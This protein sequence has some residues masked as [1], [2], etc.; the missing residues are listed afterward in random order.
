MFRGS[1]MIIPD[2]VEERG[3]GSGERLSSN[4]LNV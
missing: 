3:G 1:A 4:L 2:A